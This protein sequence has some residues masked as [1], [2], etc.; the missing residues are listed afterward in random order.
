MNNEKNAARQEK[1]SNLTEE[2]NKFVNMFNSVCKQMGIHMLGKFPK[3]R[4]ICIYNDIISNIVKKK[5]EEPISIFLMKVWANDK[6]KNSIITSDEEFFTNGNHSDLTQGD[7]DNVN[8]LFQF[9]EYWE[10]LG[11]DSKIYI[12]KAMITLVNI[13]D[14]YV[15]SNDE[16]NKLKNRSNQIKSN[17]F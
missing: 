6:Y 11:Q 13:C 10:K 1:I 7:Q 16:L 15:E 14:A 5:P 9:R 8:M 4:N 17:I 12:K 3:E 2:I